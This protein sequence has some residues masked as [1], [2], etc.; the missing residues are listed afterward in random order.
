MIHDMLDLV[1]P[2]TGTSTSLCFGRIN[3]G[4]QVFL[5][6]GDTL[7]DPQPPSLVALQP[8]SRFAGILQGREGGAQTLLIVGLIG[9]G[10]PAGLI[11][12]FAGSTPPDGWLVCDG[13]SLLR[14]EHPRLFAAI[15]TLY[16]SSGSST[17]SLPD[18]RG[19]ALVGANP[20]DAD[21]ALPGK[22]GGEKAH[23]LT[24]AEMPPH[25]HKWYT[26]TGGEAPLGWNGVNYATRANSDAYS[27]Q[28]DT[29]ETGGGQPHSNLQPYMTVNYIIKT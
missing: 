11:Q 3:A 8:N 20:N 22:A 21:F 28:P 5:E 6:P 12:A 9:G 23:T 15:G 26:S 10:D 24:V 2:T 29:T 16:G 1:M 18:L 19:R 17:F 13:S 4:G 14:S 27:T 7:I 25:S